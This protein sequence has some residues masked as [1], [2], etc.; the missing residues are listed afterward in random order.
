[1]PVEK[2]YLTPD[3]VAT[4]L[5]ITKAHVYNMVREERIPHT[6]IG[7]APRPGDKEGRRLRFDKY[8]ID[9]WMDENAVEAS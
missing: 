8:A 7:P 2:R 3:E 1:M 4:Y 5:G 9:A 6:R